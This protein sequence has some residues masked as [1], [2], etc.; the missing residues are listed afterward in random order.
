MRSTLKHASILAVL[1]GLGLPQCKAQRWEVGALGGGDFYN[2][3]AVTAPSGSGDVSIKPSFAVGAFVGNE[4]YKMLGGELRYEYLPGDLKV[5]SNGTTATFAG[6]A[7][8]IHYDFLYHFT[9]TESKI[10]PFVSAGGGIK[11]YQGTGAATETQP[12]SNLAL[13]THTHETTGMGV[14]GAGVKAFI[15]SR[16]KFRFEIKDFIS[17]VPHEVISAAPGAK[18]SGLFNN[19]VFLAGLGVTF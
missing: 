13:L 1:A 18:I 9:S 7:Q 14:V 2:S 3:V 19:V 4:M 10:R 8:A 11:I 17:P 6:Q 15:S 16:V 5:S 12:L